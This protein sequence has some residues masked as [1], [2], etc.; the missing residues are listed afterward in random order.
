VTWA[1][2]AMMES[3]WS[4]MQPELLDIKAWQTRG[5]SPVRKSPPT[6]GCYTPRRRH[7]S[8]DENWPAEYEMEN[9]QAT[10][11]VA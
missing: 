9:Q 2:N 4:G 10:N 7:S 3:S 5:N 1:A 11:I 8:P 6:K